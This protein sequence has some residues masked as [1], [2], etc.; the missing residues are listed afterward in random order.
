MS[1]PPG[2]GAGGPPP[3][4]QR[5]LSQGL[6]LVLEAPSPGSLP[7]ASA[8]AGADSPRPRP[9]RGPGG[10][11]PQPRV[12]ALQRELQAAAAGGGGSTAVGKEG[13]GGVDQEAEEEGP[14]PLA[15]SL[16]TTLYSPVPTR[17]PL[18]RVEGFA[19]AAGGA[20][21]GPGSSASPPPPDRSPERF[22]AAPPRD[23][24]AA[25]TSETAAHEP[26]AA[27]EGEKPAAKRRRG[28]Q[29]ALE[30]LRFD[31]ASFSFTHRGEAAAS[32]TGSPKPPPR[33]AEVPQPPQPPP[34]L[35]ATPSFRA[36]ESDR[37]LLALSRSSSEM[38]AVEHA[39]LLVARAFRIL[40]DRG[41]GGGGTGLGQYV[42]WGLLALEAFETPRWCVLKMR[43]GDPTVPGNLH[44]W[45]SCGGKDGFYHLTG[46]AFFPRWAVLGVEAALLFVLMVLAL[47]ER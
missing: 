32:A 4:L 7:E 35:E 18:E 8:A 30:S 20:V 16:P 12:A 33:G 5:T 24:A 31:L 42:A 47:H 46:H 36:E 45:H 27:E 10:G 23:A 29:G 13:E 38:V 37:A 6:R 14:H 39:S 19:A 34:G 43:A 11:G 2:G 3:G 25:A 17:S 26:P 28:P 9:R 40:R 41:E 15:A 1:D 44:A 21:G 22:V